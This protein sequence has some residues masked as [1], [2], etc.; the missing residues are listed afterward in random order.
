MK[1]KTW[2]QPPQKLLAEEIYGDISHI[3]FYV[4]FPWYMILNSNVR[5][6]TIGNKIYLARMLEY[7]SRRDE[8][9]II[10]ELYHAIRQG[11]AGFGWWFF[12]WFYMKYIFYSI[13]NGFPTG[14]KHPME[15]PAY[16]FVDD[17][18]SNSSK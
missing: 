4:G 7:D 9:L 18:F 10:H 17:Y 13:I 1:I 11:G 3:E 12:R 2:L 5:G 16:E 15:K 6:I 14:R 8:K